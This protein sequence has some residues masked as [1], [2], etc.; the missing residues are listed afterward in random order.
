MT[1]QFNATDRVG[2]FHRT[3]RFPGGPDFNGEAII[4]RDIPLEG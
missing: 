3:E 2:V 4:P 1:V